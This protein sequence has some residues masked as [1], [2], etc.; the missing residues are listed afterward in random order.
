MADPPETLRLEAGTA[1]LRRRVLRRAGGEVKLTTKEAALLGYLASR[2]GEDVAREDLLR[3]VWGYQG[4]I[5]TR[6]VDTAL[7]RLRA[8]VEVVPAEPRHLLTVTGL[9]YRFEPLDP[10]PAP[11]PHSLPAP[12]GGPEDRF[13]GRRVELERL[14]GLLAEARLLTLVGPAGVGKTRLA[15]RVT[16][17]IAPR[18]AVPAVWVEV[19]S[20]RDAGQA[21]RA[22]AEALGSPLQG[23][24]PDADPDAVLGAAL[25]LRGPILLV[26]DNLEQV[27]EAAASMV[28]RWLAA[29]PHLRVVATSREAL[30]LGDEVVVEVEPLG[31]DE[32]IE[33]FTAR[34]RAVRPGFAASGADADAL[35][36]IVQRLDGL[37]LAIEL[38]AARAGLLGPRAILD[39]LADRFRLLVT[40]RRDVD[41]RRRTLR[42]A[43]DWSWDLLT[44][45]ERRALAA[46]S[47]FRG[48]FDVDAAEAVLDDVES[49]ELL[50]SLRQ[51]S[52]LRST[53]VAGRGE[54]R[55]DLLESI[56]EY[57]HGRLDPEERGGVEAR[58]TAWYL[59]RAEELI[60]AL[61]GPDPFEAGR[62]L[63]LEVENLEAVRD[64]CTPSAPIPAARAALGLHA[65]LRG[66]SLPSTTEANLAG[67]D[68][69]ALPP[70]LRLRL[71]LARGEALHD[72]GRPGDAGRLAAQVGA[73]A[74]A[75]NLPELGLRALVARGH[76]ARVQG[77][78]DDA[79]EAFD[80][81]ATVA[82]GLGSGLAASPRTGAA[83]VR[84]LQMR[85][86]E[87][88]ESARRATGEARR[89]RR[90]TDHLDA[91]RILGRILARQSRH[92][93]ADEALRDALE[94]AERL[95]DRRR[96]AL[97]LQHIGM[98]Q[99]AAPP[100]I[101]A[102]LPD[103]GRRSLAVAMEVGNPRLVA[104]ALRD[105]A[106]DALDEGRAAEAYESLL[107]VRSIASNTGDHLL[108][109][110]AHGDL[111]VALMLRDR[112]GEAVAELEQGVELC[113]ASEDR[114]Y[115]VMTRA[116]LAIAHHLAGDL[117]ASGAAFSALGEAVARLGHEELA[118][119]VAAFELLLAR[120]RGEDGVAA[121]LRALRPRLTGPVGST[122]L[123]VVEA[124]VQGRAPGPDAASTT[125]I[126]LARRVARRALRS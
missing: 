47:V 26:L 37:P 72:S 51:K 7:Q 105:L 18:L 5:L 126:A 27:V 92:E 90:A 2:P 99:G 66:R 29:A 55:L 17:T 101:R 113:T 98:M 57:A 25:A 94:Q 87:A 69:G 49:L 122:L 12:P 10:A 35:R 93:E 79:L 125:E 118:A 62:G 60:A 38:A 110:R 6:A 32:A 58:H 109:G 24:R 74:E 81:A 20:A 76:A 89:A 75:A 41:E 96:I 115:A 14:E 85:L 64:R 40:S 48:G 4:R 45:A 30:R 63:R 23:V 56:R 82:E 108:L 28:G 106:V 31:A 103:A 53:S 43:L 112:P 61:E 13:V 50:D 65:A 46:C 11:P 9:G 1:D 86:D 83:L 8:K 88:E 121:R 77:R 80:G 91:T 19:A 78:L 16:S 102:R 34:A 114:T 97:V 70:A 73:E 84:L 100:A 36:P 59:G 119:H 44:E 117:E 123:E 3:D 116:N 95:G 68:A 71:L 52:L 104:Q 111:G 67:I 33:L 15:R 124:A 22:V 54:P 120:E 42:G 21:R 39:R 107:E